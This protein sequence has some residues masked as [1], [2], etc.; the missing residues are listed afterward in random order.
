[1]G[2]NTSIRTTI[3]I[4]SMNTN[5]SST[6]ILTPMPMARNTAILTH[7]PQATSTNTITNLG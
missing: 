2:R 5:T 3:P 7:I 4:A 6:L 1:M